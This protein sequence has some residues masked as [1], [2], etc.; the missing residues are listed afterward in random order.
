MKNL[1]V[2]S[3]LKGLRSGTTKTNPV[4]LQLAAAVTALTD[5]SLKADQRNGDRRAEKDEDKE[6]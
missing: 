3:N 6:I 4:A 2:Y 5:L 1:V